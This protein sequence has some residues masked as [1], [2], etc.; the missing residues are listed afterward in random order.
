MSKGLGI[1][2]VIIPAL[3]MILSKLIVPDGE[4]IIILWILGVIAMF[5]GIGMIFLAKGKKDESDK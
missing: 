3:L 4:P 1:A 5:V 2:L